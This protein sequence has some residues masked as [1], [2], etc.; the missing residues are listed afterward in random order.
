M[1]IL[2]STNVSLAPSLWS[3]LTNTFTLTNG[4]V[5]VTNVDGSASS[6]G[7]FMVSEPN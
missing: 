1:Q 6:K 2:S 3:K 7:F 5:R 4:L